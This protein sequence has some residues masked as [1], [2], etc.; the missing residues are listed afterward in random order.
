MICIGFRCCSSAWER[1][2]HSSPEQ[3]VLVDQV[4]RDSVV[5]KRL[6]CSQ[7]VGGVEGE[8]CRVGCDRND[9]RCAVRRNGVRE[10]CP[11]G[12]ESC[13]WRCRSQSTVRS[14]NQPPP[15][16]I[17][18]EERPV[19]SIVVHVRNPQGTADVAAG[20]IQPEFRPRLARKLSEEVVRV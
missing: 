8:V 13:W 6:S 15:L 1:C 5:G 10:C 14:N 17:D 20:F 18:K 4:G 9:G 11:G 16:L 3:H 7:P 12:G 19:A 2:L